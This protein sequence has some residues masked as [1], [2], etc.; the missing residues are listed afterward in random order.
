M[1]GFVKALDKDNF[2]IIIESRKQ[3]LL[4]AGSWM[5]FS[6]NMARKLV[7]LVTSALKEF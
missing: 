1:T 4:L 2:K 7:L 6:L 3:N 5:H